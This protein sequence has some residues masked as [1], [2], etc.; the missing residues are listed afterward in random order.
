QLNEGRTRAAEVEELIRSAENVLSRVVVRAPE[1]GIV[2]NIN[3]NTIGSVVRPGE[4]LIVLLPKG[5]ELIVEAR[6]SV[7]DID[8]IAIG[9]SASLRFSALNTRTTPEV[10]GVVNYISA[11]RQIDPLTREVYYTARLKIAKVLP[12]TIRRDQIF[13]GMPVETYFQTGERTFLE[14]LTKPLTD[15]FSRAFRE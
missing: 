11:D 3:K 9:Q 14:Y 13:P 6:L 2:I 12:D 8:V 1:D 5:G 15:S 4:D 7:R 10:P